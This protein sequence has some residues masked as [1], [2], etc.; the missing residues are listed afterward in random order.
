[1]SGGLIYFGGPLYRRRRLARVF[2]KAG[3]MVEPDQKV[4]FV[5]DGH[6]LRS[7]SAGTDS[8]VIWELVSRVIEAPQGFLIYTQG[9]AR[10]LPNHA[11]RDEDDRE[12]F[13]VLARRAKRFDS[14]LGDF[15]RR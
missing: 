11:F 2:R 13:S 6:R 15:P 14:Y 4:T 7:I 5:A 9:L 3:A 8:S 12:R 10:W 1:L